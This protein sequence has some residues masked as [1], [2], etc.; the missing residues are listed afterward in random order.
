MQTGKGDGDEVLLLVCSVLRVL[1]CSRWNLG[2]PSAQGLLLICQDE[3]R[4]A[5][6]LL[7]PALSIWFSL[8]RLHSR[9]T[10]EILTNG[11]IWP[12]R[13]WTLD[14]QS[15]PPGN[16]GGWGRGSTTLNAAKIFAEQTPLYV[17]VCVRCVHILFMFT[18]RNQ[19]EVKPFEQDMKNPFMLFS[20]LQ[21][22]FLNFSLLQ[23]DAW[24][25]L[26]AIIWSVR[27]WYPCPP[28]LKKYW[29]ETQ[30]ESLV[31]AQ[32]RQAHTDATHAP[33]IS[34]P[35]A[36]NGH[37]WIINRVID[38]QLAGTRSRP[39]SLSDFMFP[40][41]SALLF[42]NSYHKF[43]ILRLQFITFIFGKCEGRKAI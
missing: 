4:P 31:F 40:S 29:N 20:Q 30:F 1:R 13:H 39:F 33:S 12:A 32:H 9:W 21:N 41:S 24:A 18:Y 2:C 3:R 35:Y 14:E 8:S 17:C 42:E 37:I 7:S 22:Q 11:F 28:V 36:I 27:T 23:L 43:A 16:W 10:Y 26:F 19:F 5:R 25:H 15:T 34:M 38:A 6:L